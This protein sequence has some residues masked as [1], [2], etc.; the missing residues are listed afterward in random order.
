MCRSKP[1]CTA[2]LLRT[3]NEGYREQCHLGDLTVP[4]SGAPETSALLEGLV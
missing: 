3:V 1:H 2:A 4:S